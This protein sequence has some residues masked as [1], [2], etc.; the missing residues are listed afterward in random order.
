MK[1]RVLLLVILTVAVAGAEDLVSE[2]FVFQ[3]SVARL[4]S[5]SHEIP[6]G[7]VFRLDHID[8]GAEGWAVRICDPTHPSEN[9]CSVV[10]PPYRGDNDLQIYA[11]HLCGEESEG[12]GR[13]RHFLFVTDRATYDRAFSLLSEVLWP[14]SY[15]SAAEAARAHD[16]LHVERGLLT[17]TGIETAAVPDSDDLR[18]EIMEFEVRLFMAE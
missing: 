5:F 9:F 3:G 11:K 12:P 15:E 8:Y 7:L 18:L 1:A 14:D 2:P 4:E 6:G 10:T 16:S 13:E 17:V